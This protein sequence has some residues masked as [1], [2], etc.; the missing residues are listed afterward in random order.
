MPGRL[1][2]RWSALF[3]LVLVSHSLARGT[4]LGAQEPPE[5]P[6]RPIRFGV[7]AAPQQISWPELRAL[8]QEVESLGFDTLW[9]ND[10]LLPSVGPVEAPNMEGWTMLAAMA[11]LTSRV[12]IGALVTANTFRHPAVLAKM[13]TTIDHISGGRLILGLGSGY[14]EQEHRVYGVPFFT[15]A[16]RAGQ[17]AEAIEVIRQLW[18]EEKASFSGQY[19]Q[20]VEAPFAPK[21]LQRPHPPIMIGGAGEKL[22]LPIV[23]KYATM[24]NVG[25][26][27][28]QALAQKIA[29]LETHCRQIGRDCRDIEKS[30][31]TPLYLRPDAAAVEAFLRQIPRSQALSPEQLRATILAG[32][33]ETVRRQLQ[34]YIDVGV[35]HFIIVVRRPGFYDLEGLRLFAKEVM[36]H[37]RKQP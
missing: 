19:Y 9:V 5:A 20:L 22:T 4:L 36:P 25:G 13:A 37:F 28:P 17:L 12:Q 35:T 27:T 24:W 29:V 11:A 26:L 21:P 16:R 14:F 7:Q 31:L 32:D 23:A 18:T 3:V 30:Y 8:W 33:V 6:V 15:A 10:H 34:A 2:L 1:V